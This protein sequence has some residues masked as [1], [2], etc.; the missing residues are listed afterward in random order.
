[1]KKKKK[2][3][4]TPFDL[5]AALAGES[6]EE[7]TETQTQEQPTQPE[8][9]PKIDGRILFIVLFLEHPLYKA[10]SIVSLKAII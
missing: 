2:K 5:D 9:T 10:T 8:E 1:M 6:V 4:K 7:K 3:K